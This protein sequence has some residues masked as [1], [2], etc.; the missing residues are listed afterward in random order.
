[1]QCLY[2][3]SHTIYSI[4]KSSHYKYHSTGTAIEFMFNGVLKVINIRH[5]V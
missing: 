4:N 2:A 1:M 3:M 5:K